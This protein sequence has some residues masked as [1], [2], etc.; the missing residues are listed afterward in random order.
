MS[1]NVQIKSNSSK[2]QITSKVNQ[3]EDLKAVRIK[4]KSTLCRNECGSAISRGRIGV[5][6]KSNQLSCHNKVEIEVKSK[7]KVNRGQV[8]V[9][10]KEAEVS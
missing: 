1:D 3:I 8:N 9:E 2:S 6:L 4:M 10:R 7:S 5:K